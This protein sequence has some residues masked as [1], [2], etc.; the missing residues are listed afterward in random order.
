MLV[1]HFVDANVFKAL[2]FAYV[3]LKFASHKKRGVDLQ[4]CLFQNK[5]LS[6]HFLNCTCL[7]CSPNDDDLVSV[8]VR[9]FLP[10]L[11]NQPSEPVSAPSGE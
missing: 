8:F 10:R 3:S 9:S 2:S 4:I 11:D 1:M 7:L 6:I 5:T